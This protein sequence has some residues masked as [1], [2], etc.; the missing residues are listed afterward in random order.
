MKR[1]VW[2]ALLVGT[3]GLATAHSQMDET[4]PVDGAVLTAVPQ[5]IVLRFDDAIRLV[6]VKMTHDNAHTEALDLGEQEDFGNEFALPAF[7]KGAGQYQVDWRGLGADGH[8]M[9]GQ[10]SFTVE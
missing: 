1:L 4:L 5:E 8:I 9:K 7:A 6:T 3:A 10:F 2:I